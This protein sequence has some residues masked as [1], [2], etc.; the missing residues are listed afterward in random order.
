MKEIPLTQ[1]KVALAYM[2]CPVCKQP[3]ASQKGTQL[4]PGDGI[5]V[6]CPNRKCEAQEVSGH[7]SNETAAYKIV[8]SRRLTN[9]NR[10]TE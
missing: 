3:L 2:N 5:T 4:N 6:Y 1:N 10:E 7:G 9:E 8:M